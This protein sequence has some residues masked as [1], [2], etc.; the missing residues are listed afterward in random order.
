[1]NR[2]E[3]ALCAAK[4]RCAAGGFGLIEVAIAITVASIGV[5]GTAGVVASIGSQSRQSLRDADRTIAGRMSVHRLLRDGYA[6]AVSGADIVAVGGRDYG[7]TR[8]VTTRSPR[9][10]HVELMIVPPAGRPFE[11][12]LARDRPMPA[13]P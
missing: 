2:A 7:V 10:R 11:Y 1:M 3:P 6:S 8:V 4:V 12:L 13:A 5:L 9:L